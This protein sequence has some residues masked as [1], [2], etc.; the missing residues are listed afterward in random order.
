MNGGYF[1][2]RP[3]I[4]DNLHAGEELVI[5]GFERLV[6]QSRLYAHRHEG[7]WTCMDTFKEKQALDSKV[8]AGDTPWQVW[9]AG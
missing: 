2:L 8:E 3:E 9:K 5:E 1:V 4:F 6:R 7:F